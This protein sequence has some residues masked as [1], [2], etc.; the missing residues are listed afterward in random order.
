MNEQSQ[1]TSNLLKRAEA[2]KGK[3]EL[4][5]DEQFNY[6]LGFIEGA[7]GRKEVVNELS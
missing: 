6:V 4:L 2:L 5:T 7:I 3:L 1:E